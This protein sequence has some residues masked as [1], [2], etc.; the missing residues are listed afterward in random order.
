MI[1]GKKT[2]ESL[3]IE[4]CLSLYA[5]VCVCTILFTIPFT[6]TQ[7]YSLTNGNVVTAYNFTGVRDMF[8]GTGNLVVVSSFADWEKRRLF[9]CFH[10]G[11]VAIYDMEKEN[12]IVCFQAATSSDQ[13]QDILWID[14]C[15][16]ISC[17]RHKNTVQDFF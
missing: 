5:F 12:P 14:G 8:P 16:L 6:S 4:H 1:L 15:Y 3:K 9:I 17:D 7:M 11:V 2:K 13:E 10:S